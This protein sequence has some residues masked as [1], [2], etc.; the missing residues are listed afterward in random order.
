M[1]RW[2]ELWE[3]YKAFNTSQAAKELEI[4]LTSAPEELNYDSAI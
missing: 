4:E 1:N 3:Y 2:D